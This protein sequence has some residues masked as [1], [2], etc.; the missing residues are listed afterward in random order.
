M[1][2]VEP[3]ATV[4]E[5]GRITVRLNGI[6]SGTLRPGDALTDVEVS[7]CNDSAVDYPAVGVVLVLEHCSCAPNPMSIPQGTVER[8]DGAADAWIRLDDPAVGGGMDYLGTYANVQRLPKGAALTV[9]YRVALDASMTAGEGGLE[10]V[11]VTPD[12][13]VRLGT[14]DLPFAVAG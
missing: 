2:N 7:L 6:P 1:P 4:P 11:A 5:V 3:Y 13:L 8:W 12:P 10:A 14:A 9:R